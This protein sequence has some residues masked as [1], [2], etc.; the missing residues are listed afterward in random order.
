MNNFICFHDANSTIGIVF[1]LNFEGDK[2][3]GAIK[4][5]ENENKS[6]L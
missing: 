6:F 5:G 2:N 1:Y 3:I 4:W